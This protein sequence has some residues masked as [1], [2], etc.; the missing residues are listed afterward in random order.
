MQF[1]KNRIKILIYT[2]F[3]GHVYPGPASHIL[4]MQQRTQ[5]SS[6][7]FMPES[8]RKDIQERHEISNIISINENQDLP[9]EVDN[10]HTLCPL[11]ASPI[12]AKISVPSSTYKAT[13]ASTGIKY[14]LRRLH[15]KT[16]KYNI[17]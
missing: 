10:Y 12:H 5:L 1:R 9:F 14:C 13:H 6:A 16:F 17:L 4:D 8:M 2:I 11:E 3:S 15:G 7:F